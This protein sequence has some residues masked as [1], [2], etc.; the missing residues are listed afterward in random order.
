MYAVNLPL[1]FYWGALTGLQNGQSIWDVSSGAMEACKE[2]GFDFSF[3]FFNRYAGQI[4]PKTASGAFCALHKGLDAADTK[5]YPEDKFGKASRTNV[6]RMLKITAAYAKYGAAVDDKNGL[7]LDQVRQRDTQTGFNDVGW[8]IWPE[9]YGRFLYQ[10]DADATS[11]PRWRIGGSLTKSSSIYDRFARGFEHASGKDALYFKLHDGFSADNQ[12]K[13]MSIH[14]LWYDGQAGS[15]WKLVYDAGQ[16]SM[17][18]ACSVTG[19]GDGK[20]KSEVVTLKDAV[21]ARGGTRGSDLALINSDDKDDIFSLIEVQRGEPLPDWKTAANQPSVR[22]GTGTTDQ[23]SRAAKR[24]ER[25]KA[26]GK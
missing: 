8:D 6:D 14:V 7:L 12:P 3:Y 10:I 17:R 25:R 13:T 24:E 2:Q 22:P 9:N 26:K 11:V 15:T 23:S 4:Y 19:T 16:S 1:N 21:F 18:T 20:W 5:A